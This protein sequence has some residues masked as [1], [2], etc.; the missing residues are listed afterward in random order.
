MKC[1]F[2]I[3]RESGLTRIFTVRIEATVEKP[4]SAVE[5]WYDDRGLERDEPQGSVTVFE[6]VYRKD[7]GN[8]PGTHKLFI[9]AESPDGSSESFTR[10]WKE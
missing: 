3:A 1:T 9:T 6:R 8:H 4:I 10:V 7:E 2:T 5:A